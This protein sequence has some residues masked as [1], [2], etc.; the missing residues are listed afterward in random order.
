MSEV[1]ARNLIRAGLA[2]QGKLG[3]YD[4]L[5]GIAAAPFTFQQLNEIVVNT[6]E[7]RN[8]L[9]SVAENISKQLKAYETAR[10]A[11]LKE[12]G[13]VRE[14]SPMGGSRISDLWSDSARRAELQKNL[15]AKRKELTQKVW[16]D[17]DGA[18]NGTKQAKEQIDF[19]RSMWSDPVALLHIGTTGESSKRIYLDNLRGARP[20][21]L[22]LEIK[23]AVAT[24]NRPLLA[25]CLDTL[26]RMPPE[27]QSQ[28]RVSRQEAAGLV[29]GDEWL[30][31]QRNLIAFDVAVLDIEVA[32]AEVN[33][34]PT[35]MLRLEAG[36]K[37]R[38]LQAW[39]GEIDFDEID[40]GVIDEAGS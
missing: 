40:Q 2:R 24:Q 16:S 30:K 34:K 14:P 10:W 11:E 3:S 39:N 28:V 1:N 4:S 32:D 23:K 36:L 31:V 18:V 8:R 25:A 13:I 38:E 20:R 5:S 17:R 15:T 9:Q 21:A 7:R 35:E 12:Q 19:V 26:D 37:K 22:E 33:G 6:L 27:E 29:L